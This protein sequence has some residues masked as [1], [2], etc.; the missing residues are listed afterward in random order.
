MTERALPRVRFSYLNR[1]ALLISVASLGLFGSSAVS[2]RS[3][4]VENIRTPIPFP[5][6]L[7][8]EKVR[9][10]VIR[11]GLAKG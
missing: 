2:A 8:L 1:R 7:S 4:A 9:E 5:Q 6:N 11:G 3:A 10:T